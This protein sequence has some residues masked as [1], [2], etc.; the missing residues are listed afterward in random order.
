MD[1][2]I[3][4]QLSLFLLSVLSIT[5]ALS[6][7]KPTHFDQGMPTLRTYS[8]IIL[9][10]SSAVLFDSNDLHN[11]NSSIT[12]P[13][14]F[15]LLDVQNMCIFP[16]LNTVVVLHYWKTYRQFAS[17]LC[18]FDNGIFAWTIFTAAGSKKV[19]CVRLSTFCNPIAIM[20]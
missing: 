17:S 9:K 5:F 3:Q 1:F 2:G 13:Q 6:V 10:T 7:H 15:R 11:K 12:S 16:V 4:Q 19:Y 14:C 8:S 20:M 18:F